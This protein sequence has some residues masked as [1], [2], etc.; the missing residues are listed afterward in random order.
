MFNPLL[1]PTLK[2]L[3]IH[4]KWIEYFRIESCLHICLTILEANGSLQIF[5]VLTCLP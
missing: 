5:R 2:K 3:F 4:L 1:V